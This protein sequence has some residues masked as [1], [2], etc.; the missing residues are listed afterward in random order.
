MYTAGKSRRDT[1][2]AFWSLGS[3]IITLHD[4]CMPREK[5]GYPGVSTCMGTLP[6]NAAWH[7]HNTLPYSPL[8]SATES[9]CLQPCVRYCSD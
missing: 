8:H 6:A 4:L 7:L 9:C 1:I 2:P 5:E 3:H